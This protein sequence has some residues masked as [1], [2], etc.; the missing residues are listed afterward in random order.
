MALP[1]TI[2]V[3]GFAGRRHEDL[4]GSENILPGHFVRPN[5][6]A[7]DN[8]SRATVVL[9]DTAGADYETRIVIE[10]QLVGGT[11]DT[12]VDTVGVLQTYTPNPGE[13]GL[14]RLT[15][16]VSY[17]E[18]DRLIY[19]NDG[20]L[21]KTTGTPYKVVATIREAIDLSGESTHKLGKV[22]FA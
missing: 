3:T 5:G 1:N 17:D 19:A 20:S 11:V 10:D 7:V 4:A 6:T 18:G 13:I 16:G 21:K 22:T 12:E 15:S 2:I 9:M 8:G 14:A